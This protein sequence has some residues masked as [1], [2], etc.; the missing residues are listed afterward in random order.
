MA[1]LT[2]LNTNQK[3]I[4]YNNILLLCRSTLFYTKFDLIDTFQNRIHLIF[5]HISFIFIKINRNNKNKVCKNLY[6]E[7]FDLVFNKIEINMREIGYGDAII[8]KNMRYL[9]KIFYNI[10]FNC[11]KYKK[12]SLDKKKIFFNKYLKLNNRENNTNNRDIIEYFNKYEIFCF[13]L[14]LD[15]V[16]KGELKFNYK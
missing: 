12:M 10:L 6:Q 16:F 15:S 2:K 14:S 9:V 5:L 1:K 13:D 8:N 4:L 7:I 3:D 11:E